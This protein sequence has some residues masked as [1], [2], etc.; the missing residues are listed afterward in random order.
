MLKAA[1]PATVKVLVEGEPAARVIDQVEM[2]CR[3]PIRWPGP[4]GWMKVT[5]AKREARGADPPSPLMSQFVSILWRLGK[6]VPCEVLCHWSSIDDA[7]RLVEHHGS[8]PET[9]KL[10]QKAGNPFEI[11]GPLARACGALLG[12]ADSEN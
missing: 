10:D 12:G 4:N 9:P 8:P 11:L 1:R 5:V 3:A 6:K 7:S 2:N